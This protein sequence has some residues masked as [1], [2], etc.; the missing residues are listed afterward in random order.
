[1]DILQ[2][3]PNEILAYIV[4]ILPV[5][6]L[7]STCLVSH[8]FNA[9]SQQFLFKDASVSTPRGPEP[10][11]PTGPNA[12]DRAESSLEQLLRTLITPGRESLATH[13]HSLTLNWVHPGSRV[14]GPTPQ[15]PVS[16]IDL[17]TPYPSSRT[18]ELQKPSEQVLLLLLRL[19]RLRTLSI[20][21]SVYPRAFEG[22]PF[23][24]FTDMPASFFQSSFRFLREFRYNSTDAYCSV[25]CK[26]LLLLLNLPSIRSIN[27]QLIDESDITPGPATVSTSPVTQLSLWEV[28]IRPYMLLSLLKIPRALTHFL[29]GTYKRHD[30]RGLLE[31]GPALEP[32]RDTLQY[33][34]LDLSLARGVEIEDTTPDLPYILSLSQWPRLRTVRCSLIL[35]LGSREQDRMLRL[36]DVLP[37]T[38]CMLQILPD[39]VYSIAMVVKEVLGLLEKKNVVAPGLQKVAVTGVTGELCE[40]LKEGCNAARVELMMDWSFETMVRT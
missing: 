4:S 19:K 7:I 36:V 10:I 31:F 28:A 32:L 34:F 27:V 17:F 25:S 8:R 16:D 22:F 20:I 38:L 2:S 14:Y 24:A 11:S 21:A 3:L 40:T 23:D 29:Y 13:V 12:R 5:A 35:L 26:T 37:Y 6:D 15:R 30:S 39:R 33:L 9:I 1:M 18:L